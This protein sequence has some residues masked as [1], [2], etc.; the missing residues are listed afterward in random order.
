MFSPYIK[1]IKVTQTLCIYL[2]LAVLILTPCFSII[3]LR[4]FWMPKYLL[5]F[6]LIVYN[7]RVI[8][9]VSLAII[10][11]TSFYLDVTSTLAKAFFINYLWRRC[12]ILKCNQIGAFSILMFNFNG[13]VYFLRRFYINPQNTCFADH[14]LKSFCTIQLA[15]C[16]IFI[17]LF[18]IQKF[19]GW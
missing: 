17:A 19:S 6:S 8:S 14:D 16:S 10:G 7:I 4:G 9:F 1:W 12:E 2:V 13:D 15:L 11:L 18:H 3:T 5:P